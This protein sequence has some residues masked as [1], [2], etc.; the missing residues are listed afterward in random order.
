MILAP[1]GALRQIILQAKTFEVFS[2]WSSHCKEDGFDW[3][4]EKLNNGACPKSQMK[5]LG[6]VLRV[7]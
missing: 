5:Q 6:L 7:L 4:A 1:I 2:W 3:L